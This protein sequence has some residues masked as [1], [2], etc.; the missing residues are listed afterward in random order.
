MSEA[1]PLITYL[2]THDAPCVRCEYNLRG[3]KKPICPE[4]GWKVDLEQIRR[5]AIRESNGVEIHIKGPEQFDRAWYRR[6]ALT[7]M[8]TFAAGLLLVV[9]LAV[10]LM[11]I[12]PS[13]SSSIPLLP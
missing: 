6:A 10:V 2:A 4:C 11:A 3:I 9:V 13:S 12:G 7:L 5:K 8:I 1:N